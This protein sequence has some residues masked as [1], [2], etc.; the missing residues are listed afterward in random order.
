MSKLNI[1]PNKPLNTSFQQE[2]LSIKNDL[3]NLSLKLS[4]ARNKGLINIDDKTAIIFYTTHLLVLYQNRKGE[5]PV[6][7]IE[8]YWLRILL[9][10][11]KLF[12]LTDDK[13]MNKSFY[14]IIHKDTITIES[15]S[16]IEIVG[17]NKGIFK[18][19]ECNL[20]LSPKKEKVIELNITEMIEEN[21][22]YYT[23]LINSFSIVIPY[24]ENVYSFLNRNIGNIALRINL[25]EYIFIGRGYIHESFIRNNC[26]QFELK[27]IHIN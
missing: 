7:I 5:I 10:A 4:K 20:N 15:N 22:R 21:G 17:F 11:Q 14:K 2:H 12:N 25:D 1:V 8:E 3:S 23:Q 26:T 18:L 6:N 27:Y 24:K 19:L 16:F 9:E 13:D